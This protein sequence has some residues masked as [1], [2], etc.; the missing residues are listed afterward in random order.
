VIVLLICFLHAKKK[1][2]E[3]EGKKRFL[4]HELRI[5]R[6]REERRKHEKKKSSVKILLDLW[7]SWKKRGLFSPT[8]DN[9]ARS[10]SVLEC[11]E[12]PGRRHRSSF[13]QGAWAWLSGLGLVP[14]NSPSK[15][16]LLYS[17]ALVT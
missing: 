12:Q 17:A 9:R 13:L 7:R 14:E 8:R 15:K 1:I 16:A 5:G 2:K 3:T 4:P 6:R 11:P 10:T